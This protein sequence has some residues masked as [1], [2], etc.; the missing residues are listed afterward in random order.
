MSRIALARRK[1]RAGGSGTCRRVSW[2]MS[3]QRP[4]AV[5]GKAATK[6]PAVVGSG[7]RRAP[8]AVQQ[9]L[10]LAEELQVLQASAA[11]H[12]PA[13]RP[14]RAHGRIHDRGDGSSL[15]RS[16]VQSVPMRPRP[17][18]GEGMNEASAAAGDD[19]RVRLGDLI[20]NVAGSPSSGWEQRGDY[21]LSSRRWIRQRLLVLVSLHKVKVCWVSL[22][23]PPRRQVLE[24]SR[25][26]VQHRKSPGTAKFLHIFIRRRRFDFAC[27][28]PS[29]AMAYP[30]APSL[31]CWGR[32]PAGSES[33]P[34]AAR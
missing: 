13:D 23:I 2:M 12:S 3:K 18:P 28:R 31:S 34:S 20:V 15:V 14:G 7:V 26:F 24:E 27:L 4:D 30:S 16:P 5:R 17:G 6:S 19:T 10:V 9:D 33:F 29:A 21:F 11:P 25:C 8:Q 32:G 1:P 22:E